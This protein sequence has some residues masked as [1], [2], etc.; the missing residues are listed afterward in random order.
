MAIV[1]LA[2]ENDVISFG[3][4]FSGVAMD[5]FIPI[6]AVMGIYARENG[7]G[8]IFETEDHPAPDDPSGASDKSKVLKDKKPDNKPG[9]RIVK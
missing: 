5:I 4:R 3:G 9:L 1:D 6:N 2:L 7:Q 8:M